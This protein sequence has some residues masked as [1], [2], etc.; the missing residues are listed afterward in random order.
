MSKYPVKLAER[1]A[2]CYLFWFLIYWPVQGQANSNTSTRY[3]A[4]KGFV[5]VEPYDSIV[6]SFICSFKTILDE[7]AINHFDT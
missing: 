7:V 6:L 1:D 2:H 3:A 4:E 5:V